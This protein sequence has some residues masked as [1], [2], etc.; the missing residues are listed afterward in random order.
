MDSFANRLIYVLSVFVLIPKRLETGAAE[1][2]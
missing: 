2:P 1:Y